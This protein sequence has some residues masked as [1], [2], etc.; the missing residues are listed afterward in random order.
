ML[1]LWFFLV[2]GGRRVLN[3]YYM[4]S[5]CRWGIS[6]QPILRHAH[7]YTMS[8]V[9]INWYTS[10]IMPQSHFTKLGTNDQDLQRF[11]LSWWVRKS[12]CWLHVSEDAA[13]WTIVYG[14]LRQHHSQ[15]Q[16]EI[17]IMHIPSRTQSTHYNRT[18]KELCRHANSISPWKAKNALWISWSMQNWVMLALHFKKFV[19]MP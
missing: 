16:K 15:S 8:I 6:S 19:A 11:I 9:L 12:D 1:W 13:T 7:T 3:L 2:V 17:W 4:D 5:H 10:L 14:S 18:T